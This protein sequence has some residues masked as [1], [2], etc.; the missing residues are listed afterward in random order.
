[1]IQADYA[2]FWLS[3]A[4][5]ETGVAAS[6]SGT[7]AA[8]AQVSSPFLAAAQET[9]EASTQTTVK[10]GGDPI[11]STATSPTGGPLPSIPPLFSIS[12]LLKM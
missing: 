7:E 1:M 5:A 6:G 11:S 3:Q 2:L 8:A 10:E 9:S 4:P 12:L